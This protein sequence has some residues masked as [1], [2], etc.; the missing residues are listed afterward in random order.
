MTY[1]YYPPLLSTT[2]YL[3]P[4]YLLLGPRHDV[5]HA[6]VPLEPD[7]GQVD[8]RTPWSIGAEFTRRDWLWLRLSVPARSRCGW[9]WIR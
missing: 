5:G 3:L 2:Y 9:G 6:G 7:T 1:S 8:A 4:T